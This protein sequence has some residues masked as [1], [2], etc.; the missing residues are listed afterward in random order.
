MAV[1]LLYRQR[2]ARRPRY[3]RVELAYDLFDNVSVF[4]EWGIAGGKGSFAQVTFSNLREASQEADRRRRRA[5]RKGY[6]R[7]DRALALI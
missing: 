5:Q 6:A 1:C 7:L 3:Y 2:M 4:C